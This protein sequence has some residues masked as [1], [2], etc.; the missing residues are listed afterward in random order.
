MPIQILMLLI[1]VISAI[2]ATYD[3]FIKPHWIRESQLLS[4]LFST[5]PFY[6][7]NRIMGALVSLFCFFKIG[8][9]FLISENTGSAMLDLAT[10]LSILIPMMLLLQTLILEFGAMEFI[11][12]MVDFLFKPIFK[13]SEITAVSAISAWIGPGNA[14]ILGTKE[15]FNKGY[16]TIKEIAVIGSQFATSSIGWVILVCSVLDIMDNFGM[17]FFGMTVIGMIIADISVRIPPILN[18][19]DIYADGTTERMVEVDVHQSKIQRA[20]YGACQRA[21]EVTIK[22]FTDK[23]SNMLFYVIWL[24]PII[25]FWGTLALAISVYTPILGWVSYPVELILNFLHIPESSITAS[26]IMSGFADN[27]LPVILGEKV[28]SLESR[29]IIGMM[30]ILQLIFM[31]EI[32]T[33]LKSTNTLKSF[34]DIIIIF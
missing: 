5:T 11:G 14:A 33:L 2:L 27:Y 30:S 24:L 21:S 22:N 18:Y 26:A 28:N 34:K 12:E 8:P 13:I 32:A 10:Q 4:H 6:L 20:M 15:L 25:V 16:F 9:Y 31:S 17:I 23:K 3:M 19:P 1:F 7:F 29:T